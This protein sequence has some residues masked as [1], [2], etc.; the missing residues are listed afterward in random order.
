MKVKVTSLLVVLALCL[1]LLPVLAGTAQVE[2]VDT[3]TISYTA[4]SFQPG[5]WRPVTLSAGDE[6]IQFTRGNL[7]VGADATGYVSFGG[8]SSGVQ[9]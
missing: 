3:F 5:N 8:W 6:V 4:T 2:A 1:S 7:T 9:P